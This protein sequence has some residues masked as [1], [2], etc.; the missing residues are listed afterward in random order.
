MVKKRIS[1]K[2]LTAQQGVNLIEKI[3]LEMGFVWRPT[4]L[5]TSAT[6]ITVVDAPSLETIIL[7]THRRVTLEEA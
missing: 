2:D 7:H 1:D 5:R 6:S 3:V 4:L